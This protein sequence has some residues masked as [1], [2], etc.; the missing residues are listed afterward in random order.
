[1]KV[2]VKGWDQGRL[3]SYARECTVVERR[4]V[5]EFEKVI[6]DADVVQV[7]QLAI[8]TANGGENG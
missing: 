4:K 6:V 3:H 2:E 5:F 7:K 1:M 8:L